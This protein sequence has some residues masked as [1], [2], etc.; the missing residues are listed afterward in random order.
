MAGLFAPDLLWRERLDEV[1]QDL[2]RLEALLDDDLIKQEVGLGGKFGQW[3]SPL[4]N[5]VKKLR[6]REQD[7]VEPPQLWADLASLTQACRALRT[8]QLEF[9]GGVAINHSNFDEG[10]ATQAKQWLIEFRNRLGLG[11]PLSVIA[12]RG[13]LWE[14]DTGLVRL[15]FPDWD[16]W[17]LPSLGRALGLLAAAPG[18]KFGDALKTFADP[19][20]EQ[21]KNLLRNPAQPPASLTL[22]LPAVASTWHGYQDAV[23]DTAKNA[24][25]QKQQDFLDELADQQRHFIHYLFADMFATALI[26]PVYALA[27]FT[28]ELDYH[29]PHQLDLLDPD[30]IEGRENAPRFLPA[31]VHRAA[32][33]LAALTA[34]NGEDKRPPSQ[35]PYTQIIKRVEELWR[36][37]IRVT[38]WPDSLDVVSQNYSAWHQAIYRDVI[39]PFAFKQ[40]EETWQGAL[41]WH[42]AFRT[43]QQPA[44]WLPE[45]TALV[46]AMWYFRLDYPE[47]ADNV[48]ALTNSLLRGQTYLV[49][50]GGAGTSAAKVIAQARLERLGRRW[51]RIANLLNNEQIPPAD[52]AAVAGRFYRLLSQQEYELEY[53]QIANQG[54]NP[55]RTIW[56]KLSG[57]TDLGRPVQREALEFLGAWLV[58][59][60]KLDREPAGLAQSLHP[61]ASICD[62]AEA[63]LRDYARRTGVNW[64]ARVVLG[65]DPFLAMDTDL[66]RVRFPDWSPWNLPLMAHEFGHL[67]AHATPAFRDYQGQQSGQALKDCPR[68][69]T[70]ADSAR[71]RQ[72]RHAHLEEFFADIFA[73]YTLGP[74][75]A[76]SV[77]LTQF[78][79]AEAYLGRSDHP[80]H[81]ERAQ[82][83][84]QTLREMNQKARSGGSYTWLLD[85]LEQGWN[86]TM[87]TCQVNPVNQAVY[88]F[89][90]A[91]SLRWG[92]Q[93]YRLVDTFYRL[94]VFYTSE[95]WSGA[96]KIAKRLLKLPVPSLKEM[97]EIAGDDAPDGLS[98]GDILNAL[99]YARASN[100]QP[101]IDLTAVAHQLARLYL[102]E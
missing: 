7:G 63:L 56:S 66:V 5:E 71:Y 51:K 61:G 88:D 52:R 91:Q 6:Q 65:P 73:V 8:A 55:H 31:P 29:N 85:Q 82:V 17:H 58:H 40:T 35:R 30:Q 69:L 94:G 34:M 101:P 23:S 39:E 75:F 80:S 43:G 38:E 74:A 24:F 11:Q 70:E 54:Q 37:A 16:L 2:S 15:P 59:Q 78:N 46:S 87:A 99:W 98:L 45:R 90:L 95:R 33:I 36:A 42:G 92:K 102:G 1:E 68:P 79:P 3:L 27:V 25:R 83:I 50:L 12:G 49:P 81:Q 13:P 60:R 96:Q 84:L 44:A 97:A 22:L 47:Q 18:S 4:K 62:L 76:C 28:L 89:Q 93:L 53:R 100:P 9:L 21:V 64:S 57:L 20:V 72:A 19:L 77:I 10:F 41:A 32:V 67:V 14:P 86:Q 26:G 48:L